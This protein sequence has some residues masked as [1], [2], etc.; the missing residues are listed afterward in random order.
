MLIIQAGAQPEFVLRGQH[1]IDTR[2]VARF[3]F[4]VDEHQMKFPV[5]SQEFRFESVTF[6]NNFLNKN[7]LKILKIYIKIA[8]KFRNFSRIFQEK[9]NKILKSLR[10][11]QIVL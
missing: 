2:G 7:F 1:L 5:R 9:M 6:S 4:N 3:W 10:K 8:Q 11:F